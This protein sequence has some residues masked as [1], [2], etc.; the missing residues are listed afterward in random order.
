MLNSELKV[1]SLIKANINLAQSNPSGSETGVSTSVYM[2]ERGG[3][4]FFLEIDFLYMAR[5]CTG[6]TALIKFSAARERY[7][8]L[9]P[10]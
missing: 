6:G 4:I 7:Y 3:K 5:T 8:L 10:R 2:I 1:R 9:H